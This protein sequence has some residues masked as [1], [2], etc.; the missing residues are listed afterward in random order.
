MWDRCGE[1]RQLTLTVI[2]NHNFPTFAHTQNSAVA[3]PQP[4]TENDV[5]SLECGFC[6]L[7]SN[8]PKFDALITHAGGNGV[9]RASTAVCLF[10]FPGDISKTDAAR[11]TKLDI[12]MFHDESCKPI[13]FEIQR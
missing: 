11:I 1:Y 13:Y 10:V 5:E 9:C 8:R 3:N 6:S 2:L 4:D 7:V 12:Q